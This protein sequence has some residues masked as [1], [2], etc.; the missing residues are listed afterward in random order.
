MLLVGGVSFGQERQTTGEKGGKEEERRGGMDTVDLCSFVRPG[1]E[2]PRRKQRIIEYSKSKKSNTQ[3]P[4]L[5]S[6]KKTMQF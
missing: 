2:G 6:S 4:D 5:N 1:K 3:Q